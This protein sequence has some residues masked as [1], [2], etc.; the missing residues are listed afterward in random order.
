MSK[1]LKGPKRSPDLTTGKIEKAA[2]SPDGR[3][4]AAAQLGSRGG[5]ARARKLGAKRRSEIAS[6]AAAARWKK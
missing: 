1:K 5:K 4:R 3:N 6:K 2:E